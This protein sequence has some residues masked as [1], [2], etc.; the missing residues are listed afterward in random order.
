MDKSDVYGW[1]VIGGL[2]AGVMGIIMGVTYGIVTIA[3][4]AWNG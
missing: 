1:L 4:W 2:G 3:K